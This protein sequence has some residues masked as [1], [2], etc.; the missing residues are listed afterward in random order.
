MSTDISPP[1]KS[2]AKKVAGGRVGCIVYL[3]K[4]EVEAIDKIVDIND[5]SRS[6][7]IAQIYY[8]GKALK[9]NKQQDQ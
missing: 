4:T 5:S 2:R 7:V 8:Q 6:S 1:N 3:P 9:K